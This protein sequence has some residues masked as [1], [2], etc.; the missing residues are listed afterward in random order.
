MK[1]IYSQSIGQLLENF[2]DENPVLADKMA[3]S[4]LMDYW[5][6]EMSPA[7]SRYTSELFIKKR[8]LYIKLTSAVLKNELLLC[9]EQLVS[10]LNKQVNRNI[11]DSIVFT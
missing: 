3:E 7:V 6:N 11:I 5:T 4:R 2:L 9:R 1:R 8:I 10:N